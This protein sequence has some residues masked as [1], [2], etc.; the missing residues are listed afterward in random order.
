MTLSED[1]HGKV[2]GSWVSCL[3]ASCADLSY[4]AHPLPCVAMLAAVV[5]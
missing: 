3:A 1:Q 2:E 5:L 4:V